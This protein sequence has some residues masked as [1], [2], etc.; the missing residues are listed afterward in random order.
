ML[1]AAVKNTY[2]NKSAQQIDQI[3]KSLW[4]NVKSDD[5]LY[6]KAL[7]DLKSKENQKKQ[8]SFDRLFNVKKRKANDMLGKCIY[9]S[10]FSV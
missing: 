1:R 6:Q 4:V 9:I 2:P 10:L 7:V 3:A 8:S 5:S